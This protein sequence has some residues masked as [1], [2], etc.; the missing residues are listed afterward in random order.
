MVLAAN[1]SPDSWIVWARKIRDYR[2]A[3]YAVCKFR[4][5]QECNRVSSEPCMRESGVERVRQQRH[6][7]GF[8]F[9]DRAS[10]SERGTLHE[11]V[12]AAG[13]IEHFCDLVTHTPRPR[14]WSVR[15][16][17]RAGDTM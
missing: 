5:N 15:N 16:L 11:P 14:A 3:L 9:P 2:T 13:D 6:R 12:A 8:E 7:K 17:R 10:G 4:E 1:Q